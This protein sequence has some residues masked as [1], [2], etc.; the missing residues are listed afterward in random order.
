M[1]KAHTQHIT[2]SAL[3]ITAVI[4]S[5]LILLSVGKEPTTA[6][7]QNVVSSDGFTMLTAPNGQGT[8][9]LYVIDNDSAM[10][11][12]YSIPDPQN[13]KF[14]K[15]EASWVLPSLFNAVRN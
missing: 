11:L 4:M 14:I 9:F 3:L 13:R 7:A 2:N 10:L 12:V 6:Y 15:P 8:E 1:M 5:V